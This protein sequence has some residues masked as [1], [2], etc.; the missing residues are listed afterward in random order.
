MT[1]S[2]F[3][4]EFGSF[5]K[6][7][8]SPAI[9]KYTYEIQFNFLDHALEIITSKGF[10]DGF[11]LTDGLSVADFYKKIFLILGKLGVQA[12]IIAHP[13]SIPDSNPITT[14][15]EQLTRFKSYQADD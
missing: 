1:F 3:Y 2:F 11:P 14:P 7:N 6:V 10:Q 5:T 8:I 15:F 9:Q 4:Q 13:Y 12:K